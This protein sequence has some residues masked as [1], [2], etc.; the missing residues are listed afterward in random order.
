MDNVLSMGAALGK[1][2]DLSGRNLSETILNKLLNEVYPDHKKGCT[3][4]IPAALITLFATYWREY[5]GSGRKKPT[6][7]EWLQIHAMSVPV[8]ET[9]VPPAI[10]KE[11][12]GSTKNGGLLD[13]RRL[14]KMVEKAVA[15]A[16]SEHLEKIE[17]SRDLKQIEAPTAT[18]GR[19]NDPR[20]F[21]IHKRVNAFVFNEPISVREVWNH[22]RMCFEAR[23]GIK[24]LL[25]GAQTF[26]QWLLS[27][28]WIETF[29][30]E[31][32]GF[33]DELHDQ[34]ANP[35]QRRL[36]L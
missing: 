13:E 25:V 18:R 3:W 2:N 29:I 20:L 10:V 30:Q 35:G 7:T 33:L 32:Q 16:L 4:K 34:L 23:N 21:A 11:E 31:Y 26:P 19:E 28:E 27:Q 12:K 1:I 5:G 24:V 15:S 14:S 9:P 36:Q 17:K 8:I 6:I 22:L